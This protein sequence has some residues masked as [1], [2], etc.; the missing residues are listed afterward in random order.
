[1]KPDWDKLADEFADSKTVLIADVDCTASGKKLCEKHGVQGYP[2]IKTLSG[3]DDTDGEK[4]EGGRDLDS[5]RT[6]AGSIGPACTIDAKENCKP[7]D[8]P[9]L[10][11]YATFSQA[12]RDAKVIKLQNAIKKAEEEHE[13][14]QKSLSSQ[15]EASE[16]KLESLKDELQPQIK[17]LTAATP[18]KQ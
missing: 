8:L 6:H 9:L 18:A 4:Y 7:E 17:L 11:K 13:A 14:V 16:K 2:T 10:E 15:Y 5:L 12:R 3:P 1:M